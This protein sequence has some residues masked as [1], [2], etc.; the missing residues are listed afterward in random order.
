[1][2]RPVRVD[3]YLSVLRDETE[4]FIEKGYFNNLAYQS[5]VSA[6][7]PAMTFGICRIVRISLIYIKC[8]TAKA[9][10]IEKMICLY[11]R[12]VES[13]YFYFF[14]TLYRYQLFL[15]H[16]KKLINNCN[17]KLDTYRIKIILTS[18]RIFEEVLN[19]TL[20][21]N[22]NV[23]GWIHKDHACGNWMGLG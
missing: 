1:M 23:A 13:L 18:L 9:V 10:R 3:L 4:S 11:Y 21:Y 20:R 19:K 5:L 17:A 16:F 14:F 6:L 8:L 2:Y 7:H 22:G 12:S 15:Y